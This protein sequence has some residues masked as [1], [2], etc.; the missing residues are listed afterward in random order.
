MK[1]R[2]PKEARRNAAISPYDRGMAEIPSAG[3]E[4]CA[5]RRRKGKRKNTEENLSF[6]RNKI[7][8]MV[9]N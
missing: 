8:G 3:A 7:K 2:L 6:Y 4:E 1:S 9:L 5:K